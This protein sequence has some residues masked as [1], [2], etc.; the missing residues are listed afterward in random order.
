MEN[1]LQSQNSGQVPTRKRSQ[2]PRCP[3]TQ[4]EETYYLSPMD[5]QSLDGGLS[6]ESAEDE[7][8]AALLLEMGHIA[9]SAAFGLRNSSPK[10]GQNRQAL[11][12]KCTSCR[13]PAVLRGEKRPTFFCASCPSKGG[14]QK[15]AQSALHGADERVISVAEACELLAARSGVPSAAATAAPPVQPRQPRACPP[16][17]QGAEPESHSIE[18]LASGPAPARA[19]DPDWV[20]SQLARAASEGGDASQGRCKCGETSLPTAL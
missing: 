6:D 13:Q 3:R 20:P 19:A 5:S 17:F 12:F 8:A 14:A 7:E 16:I 11:C 10:A 4:L 18:R 2:R 1:T 15:R 9:D